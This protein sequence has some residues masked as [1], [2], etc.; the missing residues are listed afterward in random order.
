VT[1]LGTL[2]RRLVEIGAIRFGEWERSGL[3]DGLP[4]RQSREFLKA[5]RLA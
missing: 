1:E 4:L 5:T 2:T 3:V